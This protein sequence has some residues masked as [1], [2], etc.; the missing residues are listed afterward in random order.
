MKES[1]KYLE[2]GYADLVVPRIIATIVL[3]LGFI[4]I[5]AYLEHDERT[6]LMSVVNDMQQSVAEY[7][8]EN[9]QLPDIQNKQFRINLSVLNKDMAGQYLQLQPYLSQEAIDWKCTFVGDIY[10]DEIPV[11]SDD[12]CQN[13]RLALEE[14]SLLVRLLEFVKSIWGFILGYV[15]F[16]VFTR[17]ID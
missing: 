4:A 8:R 14:R 6:R 3:I 17:L 7:Y 11:M 9:K 15:L 16:I 5:P 1:V 13:S 2:A 12:F 10:K